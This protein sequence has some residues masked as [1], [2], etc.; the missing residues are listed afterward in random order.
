MAGLLQSA[1]GLI[2]FLLKSDL[3]FNTTLAFSLTILVPV[4]FMILAILAE[5]KDQE[6]FISFGEALKTSF[7]TY[8]VYIVVTLIIGYILMQ[9]WSEDDWNKMAEFQRKTMTA[10]FGAAGMDQ[11]QMEEALS[12]VT[13]AGLKEQ[14]S[15][16]GS[17]MMSMLGSSFVGLILSLII[18][19]ILKRNPTP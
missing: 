4:I 7:L 12:E 16:I 2:L 19:A 6:G 14:M 5:R 9:M 3:R 17:M 18:S 11:V 8:L 1:Y 13:S 10:M 15:G